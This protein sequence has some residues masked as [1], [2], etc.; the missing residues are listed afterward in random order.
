VLVSTQPDRHEQEQVNPWESRE[1]AE[2]WR[3]MAGAHARAF[4]SATERLLDLADIKPGMRVLDVAAGT[5]EQTLAAARRLGSTGAILATDASATMLEVAR[6]AFQQA[7]LTTV[8]TLVMDAQHLDLE[9]T[10]FDA[11][12]SRFGVML[13]PD[14]HKALE[15]IRRALRP[16]A[17][18]AA[19]YG[20]RQRRT[21]SSPFRFRSCSVAGSCRPPSR[22]SPGCSRWA[23]RRQSRTCSD[24]AD[25]AM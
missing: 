13:M 12:I 11:A 10:S 7:G 17:K 6:D 21:R 25:F 9:P 3:V 8:E 16:S 24:G 19:R 23:T 4:G 18:L 22:G 14:P 15:A 5:G 2:A 20:R 1:V